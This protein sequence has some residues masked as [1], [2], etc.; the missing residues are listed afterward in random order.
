M[1]YDPHLVDLMQQ[2]LGNRPGVSEKKM[3]GGICWMLN[4]NMLCGAQNGRY[5]FR[6]G[7]DR[8]TEALERA[9]ASPMEMGGRVMGGFVWVDAD[10]AVEAGLDSWVD[11][12]ERFVGSLPPK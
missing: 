1:S 6:V 11:L 9:G 4:G 5:M 3:F 8:L 10:E 12:A 7:K 2:V